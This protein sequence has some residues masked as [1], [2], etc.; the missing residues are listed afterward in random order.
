LRQMLFQAALATACHNPILK[1][2]A[3]GFKTRGKPHKLV[4]VAIARR[5]VTSANTILKT[6]VPWP[7]QVSAKTSLT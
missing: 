7:P 3:Q 6:G 2:I 5:S 1:Q 4:I